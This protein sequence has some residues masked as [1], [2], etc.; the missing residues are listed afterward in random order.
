M[1]TDAIALVGSSDESA[2][3]FARRFKDCRLERLARLEDLEGRAPVQ[4][5]V[6]EPQGELSPE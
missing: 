6:F 4:V 2:R 1:A 3:Y 5:V